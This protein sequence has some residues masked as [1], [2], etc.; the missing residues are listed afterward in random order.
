[1][2]EFSRQICAELSPALEQHFPASSGVEIIAEPGRYF[3]ASAYTLAVNVIAKRQTTVK[4]RDDNG[5][6]VR[7]RRT[8]LHCAY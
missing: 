1:M 2:D 4:E 5:E 3:V 8:S 7:Q 6:I